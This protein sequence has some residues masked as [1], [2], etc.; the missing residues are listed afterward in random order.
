MVLFVFFYAASL[1]AVLPVLLI[2]LPC[3]GD[4]AVLR[5]ARTQQQAV[6]V[7]L[8]ALA[9]LPVQLTTK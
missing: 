4:I 7:V 2:T 1:F 3:C 8:L 5:A 9:P 6:A